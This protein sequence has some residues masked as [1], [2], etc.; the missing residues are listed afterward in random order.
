LTTDDNDDES[1]ARH[2]PEGSNSSRAAQKKVPKRGIFNIEEKNL[3]Q[4]FA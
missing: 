3:S 2:I 1:L 4:A